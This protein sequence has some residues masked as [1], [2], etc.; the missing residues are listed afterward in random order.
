MPV[1]YISQEE[2]YQSSPQNDRL[3]H[4]EAETAINLEEDLNYIRSVILTILGTEK[5]NPD[6]KWYKVPPLFNFKD[7]WLKLLDLD[8][9]VNYILSV[10]SGLSG[11]GGGGGGGG[12]QVFDCIS[13][14]GLVDITNPPPNWIGLCNR[15]DLV[16]LS[17]PIFSANS[18][19]KVNV[20]TLP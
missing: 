6:N 12:S 19:I 18:C 1:C 2:V 8:N 10:L 4:L 14:S 3:N 16:N 9:K 13:F 20:V 17:A 5:S 7:V 11:G 15:L